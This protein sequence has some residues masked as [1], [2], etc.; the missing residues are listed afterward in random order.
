MTLSRCVSLVIIKSHQGV[1]SCQTILVIK[2]KIQTNLVN[3][4]KI[5]NAKINNVKTNIRVEKIK[6]ISIKIN[7]I[8]IKVARLVAQA[9][10]T[11]IKIG[12]IEKP[13]Y[14]REGAVSCFHVDQLSEYP[15]E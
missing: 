4:V 12:K 13:L 6:Q 7:K 15:F 11:Q 14:L 9:V 1:V 3:N 10:V 2:V 5:S 8:K